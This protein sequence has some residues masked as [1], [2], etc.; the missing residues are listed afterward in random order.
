MSGRSSRPAELLVVSGARRTTSSTT[1]RST[2]TTGSGRSPETGVRVTVIG[3]GFIG[4]EISGCAGQ[5]ERL[6]RDHRLPDAASARGFFLR[7]PLGVRQRVLP[8][9]GGRRPAR[10]EG[11]RDRSGG[12]DGSAGR[13]RR[14]TVDRMSTSSSPGSASNREPTLPR[15]R[16]CARRRRA[17]GRERK[18]R[19]A[20]DVFAAGDV[21]RFPATLLGGLRESSTRTMRRHTAAM[22]ARTWPEPTRPTTTRRSSTSISSISATR[23]S[24]TWTAAGHRRRVGRAEPQGSRLL[25]RGRQT[26]RVPA[27]G[28]VG[29]VTQPA[30]SIAAGR[31]VTGGA[32]VR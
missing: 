18:G 16:A 15:K 10:R 13:H 27:L 8:L 20:D 26:A 32:C 4:S 23:M 6:R 19:R 17:R 22:S 3:G 21:A 2:R 12:R 24:G 31:P 30:R 1:A 11:C 5:Y 29:Q 28:R 7:E 25:R 9:E 14:R